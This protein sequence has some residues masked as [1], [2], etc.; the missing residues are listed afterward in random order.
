MKGNRYRFLCPQLLLLHDAGKCLLQMDAFLVEG[1][2]LSSFHAHRQDLLYHV[3]EFPQLVKRQFQIGF[4]RL[5]V[6]VV[7]KLKQGIIGRIRHRYGR[8]QLMRDV[9]CEVVLHFFQ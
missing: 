8:L 7:G 1:E 2:C 3:T 5:A 6:E 9:V 4:P